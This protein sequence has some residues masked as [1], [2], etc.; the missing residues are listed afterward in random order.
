[1]T[2]KEKETNKLNETEIIYP[3]EISFDEKIISNNN[4]DI[5]NIKSNNNKSDILIKALKDF[6]VRYDLNYKTIMK[7]KK[8]IMSL[9]DIFSLI[10]IVIEYQ[11]KVNN[12]L[13]IKDY[14]NEIS[15]DFINN[16]NYF[17]FSN[18]KIDIPKKNEKNI[19]KSSNNEKNGKKRMG[20]EIKNTKSTKKLNIDT[21][22]KIF[23]TM[24]NKIKVKKKDEKFLNKSLLNKSIERKNLTNTNRNKK[25][26]LNKSVDRRKNVK[27]G[28]YTDKRYKNK[29]QNRSMIYTVCENLKGSS[30]ILKTSRSRHFNFIDNKENKCN[31][32]YNYC[33]NYN[34]KGIKRK[35]ISNNIFKPSNMANKLLQRGI[36]YLTEFSNIKEEENRKKY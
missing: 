25:N 11:I 27:N 31:N 3:S 24:S 34:D 17:I 16:L 32:Y 36:K 1:M 18:E 4:N 29:I 20:G 2:N 28:N 23:S 15:E 21:Q 35:I 33:T 9:E 26:K 13:N 6:T 8:F 19:N 7:S 14:L 30:C 22:Q 5:N 12:S 10:K